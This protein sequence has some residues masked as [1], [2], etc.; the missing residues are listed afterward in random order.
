M[1]KRL[2][3]LCFTFSTLLINAQVGIG[4][5]TPGTT[6][7]VNGGVTYRETT[8]NVVSN[9]VAIPSNVSMVRITGTASGT[10]SISAPAPPNPGQRLTIYNNT[11]GGF[12][13]VLN[14]FNVPFNQSADFVYSNGGWQSLLPIG[15][16]I[17]PYA[18]AAPATVTTLV[19]GLESTVALVGFGN[20]ISGIALAGSV[21]DLT[22]GSGINLNYGF[23]MP[24]SGVVKSISAVFSNVASLSLIGTT[25]TLKVQLYSNSTG[26]SFSPVV[27]ASAVLSPGLTGVVSLGNKFSGTINGLSIPVSS[28][29]RLLLVVSAT[30]SGISLANIVVGYVSAGVSL[31]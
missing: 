1:K 17:I 30:A 5:T 13:S 3:A 18:S 25:V 7:D 29:T 8:V 28:Q 9:A 10:I 14:S 20:S 23:Y 26:N 22:G 6:L 21:I 2:L 12:T 15:G 4:T 27:G 11:V 16:T 24:R 19:S 31:D